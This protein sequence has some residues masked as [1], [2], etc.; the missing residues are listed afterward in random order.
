MQHGIT[1]AYSKPLTR[2]KE[3]KCYK[4]TEAGKVVGPDENLT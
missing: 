3:M 4:V 1:E 2:I